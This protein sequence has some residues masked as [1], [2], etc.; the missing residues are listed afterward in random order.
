MPMLMLRLR[1]FAEQIYNAPH[2]ACS[3]S[4]ATVQF[5]PH[6]LLKSHNGALC[7]AVIGTLWFLLCCYLFFFVL[8]GFAHQ[9]FFV[10]LLSPFEESKHVPVPVNTHTRARPYHRNEMSQPRGKRGANKQRRSAEEPTNDMTI[11]L[12]PLTLQFVVGGEGDGDVVGITPFSEEPPTLHL[13]PTLRMDDYIGCSDRINA[14]AIDVVGRRLVAASSDETA[15][16]WNLQMG[17][18]DDDDDGDTKG[19]SDEDSVGLRARRERREKIDYGG[20]RPIGLLPHDD[21]VNCVGIIY[22]EGSAV[23][24]SSTRRDATTIGA[25]P[26]CTG[27]TAVTGCEDG[28]LTVWDLDASVVTF[29]LSLS[30]GALTA[31]CVRDD[32]VLAASLFDAFIVSCSA[33]C[34]L[35]KFS[36]RSDA[37]AVAMSLNGST[38]FIGHLD[39]SVSCWDVP[40]GTMFREIAQLATPAAGTVGSSGGAPLPRLV[41]A[42][43]SLVVDPSHASGSKVVGTTDN[44]YVA[45][46]STSTG[47]LLHCENMHHGKPVLA[48]CTITQRRKR[49]TAAPSSSGDAASM[50]N[51]KGK[52]SGGTGGKGAKATLATP[53]K[54]ISPKFHDATKTFVVSCGF[55][56]VVQC[57]DLDSYEHVEV[58][59]AYAFCAATLVC[60]ARRPPASS[61]SANSISPSS[62]S[63][64]MWF[65]FVGDNEGRVR[66]VDATTAVLRLDEAGQR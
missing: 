59:G 28:T 38:A 1:L 16:V 66:M 47:E 23:S 17:H 34:Q 2:R 36:L 24:P 25:S 19:H 51:G 50:P 3:T 27:V 39:G 58:A 5:L 13:F 7:N 6:P 42:V 14:V 54:A 30:H 48:S 62:A 56:G 60:Q 32:V 29:Q 35:R 4:S 40:S 22:P 45:V 43:R 49:R 21:W 46:W 53:S 44:G 57:T 55:D 10:P 65:V 52:G 11:Q 41:G 9:R 61:E 64:T 33:Q 20:I 31:L 15:R 12:P 37:T 26:Q 8:F 18:D 63:D